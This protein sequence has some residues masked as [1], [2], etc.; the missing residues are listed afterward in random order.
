MIK[1][2]VKMIVL[3]P[4]ALIGSV[5]VVAAVPF[6]AIVMLVYVVV[7]WFREEW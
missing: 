2:I 4:F 5:V 6:I 3:I 7:E 1:E